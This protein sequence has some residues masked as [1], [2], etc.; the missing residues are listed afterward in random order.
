MD[1][2]N[3]V[4]LGCSL[5][6]YIAGPN[7]ELDWL[8]AIPIPEGTDMGYH[9][10]MEGIDA[11]VMGRNTFEKVLSF[12]VAWPYKKPVFVLSNSLEEI[13]DSHA[14]KAFLITGTPEG[15]VT[16]L[17]SKGYNRLYIDGG[18][19]VQGFMRAGL[20]DEMTLTKIP[21]VLG[22]GISLWGHLEEPQ[23]F[24]LV[25]SQVFADHIVQDKYR[26]KT[27]S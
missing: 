3:Y 1:S 26:R 2:G 25:S 24:E 27:N 15:V 4:Y 21:V 14:D 9:T 16:E 13:P 5:D 22:G 20:I 7:D 19:T 11:L 17:N 18:Q 6:G 8:D 23:Q 12:D 10:F